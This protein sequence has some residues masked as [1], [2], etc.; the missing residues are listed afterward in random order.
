MAKSLAVLR[1]RLPEW[2]R[3]KNDE[4]KIR[5]AL[6][7]LTPE[8]RAAAHSRNSSARVGRQWSIGFEDVHRCGMQ[9]LEQELKRLLE[10]AWKLQLGPDRNQ[11]FRELGQFRLRINALQERAELP[12][13][14]NAPA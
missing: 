6:Q 9:E 7:A 14:K 4:S 11:I 5:A 3:V 12:E 2:P 8:Y 13:R 10:M 1:E